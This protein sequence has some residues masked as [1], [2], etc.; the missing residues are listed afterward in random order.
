MTPSQNDRM[1]PNMK[2]KSR[3]QK[4]IMKI[5]DENANTEKA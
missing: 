1:F 4:P 3:N 5:E 2:E